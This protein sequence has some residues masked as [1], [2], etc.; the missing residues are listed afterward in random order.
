MKYYLTEAG[1]N[2][3]NDNSQSMEE[4]FKKVKQSLRVFFNRPIARLRKANQDRKKRKKE[5]S[6]KLA[7]VEDDI[8]NTRYEKNKIPQ[9]PQQQKHSDFF[10]RIKDNNPTNNN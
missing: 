10:A 5:M 6:L 2:L 3:L 1:V 9:N 4:D 7:G 8:A